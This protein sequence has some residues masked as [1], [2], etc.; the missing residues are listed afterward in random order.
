MMRIRNPLSWSCPTMFDKA[1][2]CCCQKAAWLRKR[3]AAPWVY[4][5]QAIDEAAVSAGETRQL[6]SVTGRLKLG[7]GKFANVGSAPRREHAIRIAFQ[8]RARCKVEVLRHN[9]ERGHAVR[10]LVRVGCTNPEL[11]D[12]LG[13]SD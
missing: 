1:M 4:A 5:D 9:E 11:E 3:A 2:A 13:K 8:A 6:Q 12:A 7:V 10:Y